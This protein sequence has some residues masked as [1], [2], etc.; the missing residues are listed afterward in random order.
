MRLL[1]CYLTRVSL[2]GK[3]GEQA[4]FF[5]GEQIGGEGGGGLHRGVRLDKAKGERGGGR[6]NQDQLLSPSGW[7]WAIR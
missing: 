3:E 5:V 4:T 7:G 2:L 1:P 6:L